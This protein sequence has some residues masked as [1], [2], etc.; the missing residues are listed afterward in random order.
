M[1]TQYYEFPNGY[2]SDFGAE[3]YRIPEQMFDPSLIKVIYQ[4][5]IQ[6]HIT[7]L[8]MQYGCNIC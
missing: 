5:I 1:P 2:N 4:L 6:L 3:R 8:C 7:I